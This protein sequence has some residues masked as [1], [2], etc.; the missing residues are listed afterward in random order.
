M[1]LQEAMEKATQGPVRVFEH[2]RTDGMHVVAHD[3]REWRHTER[4]MVAGKDTIIARVGGSDGAFEG[5]PSATQEQALYNAALVAHWMEHGPKLLE[6][7]TVML[8]NAAE[9]PATIC[10]PAATVL[11]EAEEVK[12]I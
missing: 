10:V 8:E 11:N 2:L 1:K 9:M 7:L 12:G 6:A 4:S 5:Y 3:G